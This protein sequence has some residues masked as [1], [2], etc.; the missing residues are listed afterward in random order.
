MIYLMPINSGLLSTVGLATMAK[1]APPLGV[2][3]GLLLERLAVGPITPN[4]SLYTI[5]LSPPDK[6]AAIRRRSSASPR[7]R[8]SCP[9]RWARAYS[10]CGPKL[11]RPN[12]LQD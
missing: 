2:A 6:R 12:F 5:Q 10:G 11:H 3:A 8:L 9:W 1:A 7:W 4:L